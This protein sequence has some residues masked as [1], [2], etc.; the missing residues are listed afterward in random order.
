MNQSTLIKT[1]NAILYN[2]PVETSEESLTNYTRYRMG[3]ITADLLDMVWRS[4]GCA[5]MIT[6]SDG[7]IITVNDAFCALSK[8][9]SQEVIGTPMHG[10]F[11]RSVDHT[12]FFDMH[13]QQ[14]WKQNST[15]VG[16]HYIQFNSGRSVTG[17]IITH[18]LVD[19]ADEVFVF[20]EYRVR[21]EE[22]RKKS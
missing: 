22:E 13:A 2:R 15:T 10:L 18:R 14:V 4:T 12:A 17:E 6:D 3:R 9:K 8:L 11:D 19:K 16:E 20:T 21:A 5:M 1:V 7:L